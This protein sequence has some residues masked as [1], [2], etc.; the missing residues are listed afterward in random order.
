MTIIDL[1]LSSYKNS[2]EI[3]GYCSKTRGKFRS[4]AR[5]SA[6][7]DDR[8][9]TYHYVRRKATMK[10]SMSKYENKI[11]RV[12]F[13]IFQALAKFRID[14]TKKWPAYCLGISVTEAA[15]GPIKVL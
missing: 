2:Y 5:L 3:A 11:Y 9:A 12:R 1:G 15:N 13:L 8:P 14:R 4:E 10:K 6:R 7:R